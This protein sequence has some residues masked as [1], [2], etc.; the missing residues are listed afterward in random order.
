MKKQHNAAFSL[1]RCDTEK[2]APALAVRAIRAALL[3]AGL[4]ALTQGAAGIWSNYGWLWAA[5]GAAAL[6]WQSAAFR[7]T[8][9]WLR[10]VL[11]LLCLICAAVFSGRFLAGAVTVSSA[12]CETLTTATGHMFLPLAGA[13]ADAA[14]FVGVSAALL[15]T[16][17]AYA[18]RWSPTVCGLLLTVLSAAL[19]ALLRPDAAQ[20]WMA[21]CPL[22]AA[23]LLA[24]GAADHRESVSLLLGYGTLAAAAAMLAAALLAVPGLRSGTLFSEWGAAS[25]AALH[26]L[27]YGAGQT[28]LPEGDF[29]GFSAAPEQT[30]CLTV[31]MEQPAALY[32]RGFTGD[33]FTGTAWQALDTQ[34]LAEQSDLIYWL[35]KE[36][37]YPQMQLAAA[38]RGLHRQEQTQT[39]LIENTG[40][41]SAYIYAPYALCALPQES[42]LRTDTLES[43]QIPAS[44]LRGTR[45]YRFTMPLAPEQTTAELLDA[46]REQPETAD[47]YL[48]AEGSYRAFVQ[49]QDVT[50]SAQTYTQLAP[51]LDELCRDYGSAA[52]LTPEQAQ[53]C[54][55]RFLQQ[56]DALREAG[57]PLPL[58]ELVKDTTY[59][60]ATLTVLAL[61]YYGIPA[62]YAEG[63]VLTQET[64]ARVQAGS[65]ITLTAADAQGWAE[66]YQDGV[67]W[68][69][70]ALTPGYGALTDILSP[71]QSESASQ[72][73]DA[74]T[75]DGSIAQAQTVEDETDETEDT[76]QEQ[77]D[78][79][80]QSAPTVKTRF[81]LWILLAVGLLLL[82]LAAAALRYA[83]IRRRWRYRFE[84]TAPAQ[85]VA[86]VAK[87]LSML[88]PAMGLGYDGGSVFA[89]GESLRE[90][91]AEYAGAVR[92]LAALN[93][94]ARFSSHAM[95]R[96]QAECARQVWIQTVGRLQ[97]TVPLP[98]RAW[99]KWA[100]CLY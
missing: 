69:P 45:Q 60:T 64:A 66:V 10:A 65:A 89:F 47:A 21:V 74:H 35:H 54:T 78:D 40:A 83:L 36:G 94:E 11:P 9:R 27:R 97:K 29:S 26:E 50:L 14:L 61:R 62:R 42:A 63:F 31:T 7:F 81:W 33:T 37:F 79:G 96:E 6:L 72:T 68:M 25:R 70:L 23:V 56:L 5:A 91:D 8:R 43:T 92:E 57:T 12:A 46:L 98:R 18:V 3:Y 51:I 59:Q 53:L 71:H 49:E 13:G 48:S 93:G 88:W 38:S 16:L 20:V 85:S 2:K 75:D 100:R 86:W 77:P 52:S 22:C 55:A 30:P 17:C 82:L 24:G 34:T 84:R 80:A 90:T 95:T 1:I 58:D 87:A 19:L 28:V 67:G 76:P 99:L 44:G 41:C 39:V 15:G 4:L 32:L 73:G